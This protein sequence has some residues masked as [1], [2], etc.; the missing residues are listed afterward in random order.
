MN[1]TIRFTAPKYHAGNLIAVGTELTLEDATAAAYVSDGVAI[2][3][4]RQI[5]GDNS[6]LTRSETATVRSALTDADGLM[7]YKSNAVT[8]G[9]ELPGVLTAPQV[10]SIK[11]KQGTSVLLIGDSYAQHN[12]FFWYGAE[13]TSIVRASDVVTVTRTGHSLASGRKVRIVNVPQAGFDGIH[14]ITVTGANTFTYPSVGADATATVASASV[15]MEDWPSWRGAFTWTNFYLGGSLT[16]R[17]VAVG[18]STTTQIL[19]TLKAEIQAGATE[20]EVWFVGCYNDIGT[21]GFTAQTTIDNVTEMAEVC[22]EAGKVFRLSTMS[23]IGTASAKWSAATTLWI[24]TVNAAIRE[25]PY[26]FKNCFVADVFPALVDSTNTTNPGVAKTGVI[27]TDGVHPTIRAGQ[28]YGKAFSGTFAVTPP[29]AG[30]LSYADYSATAGGRSIVDSAP[31]VLTGGTTNTG[32]S[33]VAGGSIT[34]DRASGTGTA[35][36]S[37]VQPAIGGNAQRL[38]ITSTDATQFN[39]RNNN[40]AAIAARLTAGEKRKLCAYISVSGIVS[41]NFRDIVIEW[42]FTVDGSTYYYTFGTTTAVGSGADDDFAGIVV[43]PE[44]EVPAG[45]ITNSGWRAQ[46][47]TGGASADPLTVDIGLVGFIN[48]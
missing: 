26:S 3:V 2:F 38:V 31:W 19:A 47:R 46:I 27:D 24:Q 48:F 23:P 37:V 12:N 11:A 8:G 28:E 35:V 30:V 45:T 17:N 39:V 9:I 36:A 29:R 43:G 33:G 16:A 18:G 34:I 1:S 15:I 5:P 44:I 7:G 20:Q 32:S 14:T 10:G 42:F 4:S 22:A 25:L 6:P 41:P 13:I 21:S 40:G